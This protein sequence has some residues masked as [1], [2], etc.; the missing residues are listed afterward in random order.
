MLVPEPQRVPEPLRKVIESYGMGRFGVQFGRLIRDKRGIEGLSQDALAEKTDLTKSRI[1]EIET[2]KI[3][4]PQAKTVDA[5]CVALNI[6]REERAACYAPSVSSLPPSLLERLAAHFGRDMPDAT[7]NELEAFLIT[8]ANEFQEMRARLTEL[9]ATDARMSELITAAN[10]AIGE[11]DFDTAD[12]LLSA[13]EDVQLQSGTI[14]A[15]RKQAKLRIE[16]GN[17]AL[18]NGDIEKA[19][20]H[21]DLSSRYFSGIQVE[22]EAENR[23]DCVNLLRA[24]G[25]RYKS[26]EA[27]YV[28][29]R[30]LSQNLAIWTQLAHTEKWC[31]TENALGAVCVRLSEFDSSENVPLHLSEGKGHYENVRS[32]CSERFLPKMFGTA[33]L[34]LANIYSNRAAAKTDSDHETNLQMAL[35]L[36]L[37]ALRFFSQTDDPRE[38]GIIQHN[39]G[40]SYIDLSNIRGSEDYSAEDAA[41]AI[42]HLESSFA[43]RN[44]ND[45]LQYWVASCRSLGEALLNIASYSITKDF[46]D[47]LRRA[48][49]VLLDAEGKISESD[50]PHQWSELQK[51]ILRCGEIAAARKDGRTC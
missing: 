42:G 5:L 20:D 13:A 51:Q 41:N 8:K 28:A 33:E 21:F 45:S 25:Y 12:N 38:W 10:A 15:L 31:Q 43:V 36:Q 11:G 44:P 49:D 23:H 40:C 29:R 37:S 27:L 7:E 17:A 50:H 9:A 14:P 4:N 24:Y 19:A 47:Y 34:D 30:F 35:S 46:T 1:S 32:V 16:R 18:V 22:L 2:G 6:S 26:P 3:A 48:S 39:L